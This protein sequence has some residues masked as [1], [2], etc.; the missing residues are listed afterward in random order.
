MLP[1]QSSFFVSILTVT[2]Y[3]IF[4]WDK[5]I[6]VPKELLLEYTPIINNLIFTILSN[7]IPP[8]F[9]IFMEFYFLHNL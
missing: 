2:S 4:S 9:V 1:L 7:F 6:I 8:T 5:E 3:K